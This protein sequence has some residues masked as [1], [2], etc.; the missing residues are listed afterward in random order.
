MALAE[1]VVKI[2]STRLKLAIADAVFRNLCCKNGFTIG[3]GPLSLKKMVSVHL[4]LVLCLIPHYLL[5]ENHIASISLAFMTGRGC[6]LSQAPL[7]C[8]NRNSSMLFSLESP[9]SYIYIYKKQYIF[10]AFSK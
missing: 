8:V 2:C 9:C 4:L 6:D 3:E 5:M 7:T 1:L 10:T